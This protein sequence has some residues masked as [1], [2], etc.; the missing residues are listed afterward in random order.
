MSLRWHRGQEEARQALEL[1]TDLMPPEMR[2]DKGLPALCGC[3]ASCSLLR[4][5][6]AGC[7]FLIAVKGGALGATSSAEKKANFRPSRSP[8]WE[9]EVKWGC[10]R[11]GGGRADWGTRRPRGFL[12]YNDSKL[13]PA[14]P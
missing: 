6:P 3:P 7:R 4:V 14:V 8:L 12:V 5:P 13:N 11:G 1:S 9:G 10:G 2:C